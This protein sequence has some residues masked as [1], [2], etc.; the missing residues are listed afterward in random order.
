MFLP[1]LVNPNP[2]LISVL[3][4]FI[5]AITATFVMLYDCFF[6][7]ENKLSTIISLFGLALAAIVLAFIW[8]QGFAADTW[9][10]MIVHDTLR[11][12]FSFVFLFISFVTILLSNIWIERE[13]VPAGEYHALLLFA[14]FGM[15]LMASGNDLVVIFLGLETL[16]IATYVMCGLRK[17]DLRSNE[18]A[19]KYFILGSFASAFLLYGMA[20]IY[21]ATG[22]T[23]ITHIA[24][25][26]TSPTFPAL[27]LAGGAMMLIGFGFKIATVP[28]HIW[29]PDV[30]E[31][32]PTPVTAFL[33]SVGKVAALGALVRV[34]VVAFPARMD[35]W[36]PVVTVLALLTLI[37]GAVLAVVQ[38][39]VKRMLAY[40][41]ITHAGFMLVG[42]EAASHRGSLGDNT[43]VSATLT[44]LLIYSVIVV[45]TFGVVSLA[46]GL[47]DTATSVDDMRGLAKRRPVLA[48]GLTVL[49]LAQAGVPLT[50]GFV[51]KF[52]VIQAA[53]NA[54]S[55]AL[56]VAAM[57]SA[58]IA[59]FLY[60]RIMVSVW[61][62][63]T[64]DAASLDVPLASALAIGFAVAFTLAIGFFPGWLLDAARDLAQF[65]SL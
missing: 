59:A 23:N 47:G 64:Q 29:T 56:A 13:D 54:G 46:A 17:G 6:P 1:Q 34:F 7:K 16:S 25:R 63:D 11:T 31:G 51:A 9:G 49:L 62:H 37:I 43:G 5:V 57:V 28:F 58:V 24:E 52:G 3:P 8:T 40:S 44:Y 41:S 61:L 50:S 48:L 65:A 35:D 4:E 45:G 10:G 2:N 30:Y 15:M 42:L 14:T 53:V 38:T 22:S 20:L 39:D 19:M 27:L 60:L 55:Y 36:R 12:S 33:S 26:I 18:S 32:A 21:G